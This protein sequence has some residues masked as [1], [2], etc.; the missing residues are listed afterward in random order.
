MMYEDSTVFDPIGI[1]TAYEDAE[2]Q[3]EHAIGSLGIDANGYLEIIDADAGRE[4]LLQTLVERINDKA[5]IAVVEGGPAGQTFGTQVRSIPRGEASF[6][7]ALQEYVRTYY[8]V[9]LV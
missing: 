4:D 5:A 1:L 2:G 9:R 3:A 8:G 7:A 6:P